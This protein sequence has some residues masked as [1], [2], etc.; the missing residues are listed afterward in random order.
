MFNA[1]GCKIHLLNGAT[2]TVFIK[3]QTGLTNNGIGCICRRF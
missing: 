3:K 1:S 2:A